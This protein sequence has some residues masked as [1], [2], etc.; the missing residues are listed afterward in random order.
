M[1]HTQTQ[2][3]TWTDT[4]MDRVKNGFNREQLK[5]I[6]IVNEN[7]EIGRPI[8]KD[9]FFENEACIIFFKVNQQ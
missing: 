8:K 1:F 7:R 6:N 2:T 3:Q 5:Q 4:D 9:L